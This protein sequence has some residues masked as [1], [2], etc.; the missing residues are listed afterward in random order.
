[1]TGG[2]VTDPDI[3]YAAGTVDRKQTW[4][5]S[6]RLED[7]AVRRATHALVKHPGWQS[8]DLAAE[9]PLMSLGRPRTNSIS[10]SQNVAVFAA[11]NLRFDTLKL[12]TGLQTG[13]VLNE[14]KI[15]LRHR[16]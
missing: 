8:P 6:L 13:R 11:Q 4:V 16:K 9:L 7:E 14:Q 5:T 3:I 12:T 10:M 2:G 15:L 1:M